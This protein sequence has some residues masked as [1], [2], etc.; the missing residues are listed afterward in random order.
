M[1]KILVFTSWYPTPNRPQDHSFVSQQ[2]KILHNFIENNRSDNW[3]FIVWHQMHAVDW[4]NHLFRKPAVTDEWRDG[5]IKIFVAQGIIPSHR[6]PVDQ[7]NFLLPAMKETYKKVISEFDGQPDLVW[8]VT[9]SASLLWNYF[10]SEQKF[11]I[12]YILQEHSNPLKMHLKDIGS[13]DKSKKALAS[14]SQVIVVAERQIAEFQSLLPSCNPLVVWNS[15]DETF[16]VQKGKRKLSSPFVFVFAGRLSAEKG[17]DRLILACKI[18]YERKVI[19]T[20]KIIGGG[21]AESSLKKMVS[22]LGL[23]HSI[24]FLGSKRP[25]EISD[26]LES[27]HAFVLPSHYE[28]CPVALL[29]AQVKGLPCICTINGASE[30]VLLPGNGFTV[31]ENGDGVALGEAMSKMIDTY[32]QFDLDEVRTKSLQYFS[33]TVFAKRMIEIIERAIV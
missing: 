10:Q 1:K 16:L 18:L 6:L 26:L 14:V 30:K 28:N 25:D 32:K 33:P 21:P 27:C 9:L 3:K 4:F 23:T 17:L 11:F 8:T 12:P 29:E 7:Y 5:P 19:F 13:I 15:V 31:N 2:V 22:D 20:L 24:Q